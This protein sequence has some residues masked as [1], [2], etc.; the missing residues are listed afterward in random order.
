MDQG[1]ARTVL[2]GDATTVEAREQPVPFHDRQQFRDLLEALPV[3]IYTTD[4][5]G[6]ITFCNRAAV[7]LA[8]RVPTLGS[9]EWC[10]TWRLY[11]PDG[12][13]LPHDQCPM[14]VALRENRVVRGEESIAERPDGT[15]VAFMPYPTPLRDGTGKLIGAVNLLVDITGAKRGEE[16]LRRLSGRL[17]ERV[18]E[19]TIE[20]SDALARLQ[21]S[22]RR[23]RLLVQGVTDYAIFMLDPCGIIT[24]W[25]A[26][27]ERIKGYSSADIIGKPFSVFYSEADRRAGVPDRALLTARHS[28]RFEGEGWRIRKDGTRFWANVIIDAIY[29]ESGQLIGF[30][31]VTRDMTER[32]EM[33][34]QLRHLQKLEAIG[35]LTG[36]VAHDFNNLLT[37]V[38]ANIDFISA[39]ADKPSFAD[40]ERVKRHAAAAMR[41][42]ARGAMLT[43]QLLAFARKQTLMPKPT[44]LNE[45][46]SGMSEMLLR[47]LGGTIRVEFGLPDGLWSALVD[48]AQIESVI[49]NLVINARDAMPNGG[50]L[51][52]ET[53]NR[54]TGVLNRRQGL[55]PG[56]YVLVSVTDTG[57]GMT[58]DVK[59]KAFD[60][61]FT[62][63]DVGKGSGLGLSQVY[64]IARQSGGLAE[65]DSA[66]GR[67]TTVR[68]HLP[69]AQAEAR[70]RH[71]SSQEPAARFDNAGTRVLL[72]DDDEQVR[73]VIAE[74]LGDS[75][76]AVTAVSSGAAVLEALRAGDYEVVVIDFAMPGMNGADTAALV[77]AEHP[78]LPILFIT[79]R[80]DLPALHGISGAAVLQKP[81]LVAELAA[82]LRALLDSE[83]DTPR[84]VIP[85]R[86]EAN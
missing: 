48:P 60:P 31:K 3:A 82:K 6:H 56:D 50:S 22:E 69:R 77:R 18:A 4:A 39:E 24:N 85:L 79:G 28:G 86:R 2:A 64:G 52:I 14:A 38:M 44:N 83:I 58:E 51:T 63:K 17:E 76:C 61:F 32:R 43:Q 27:A 81:F 78:D 8:G 47:T 67:G 15:R 65:L 59:A 19:R 68:I 11:K 74:A 75:G 25:N 1:H 37:A 9:D 21:Q 29:D 72:A 54:R 42:A 70:P 7:E 35:Q 26:G 46:V 40:V 45:L 10:V 49:L 62:T 57:T 16:Q 55:E 66:V 53:A 13:P 80:T 84:K 5:V 30:A 36:G 33:E 73:D 41:A 20:L 34:E 12:T 23:F 71:L